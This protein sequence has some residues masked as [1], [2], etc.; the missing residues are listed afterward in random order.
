MS[1]NVKLKQLN[2]PTI[3]Q[4]V[5]NYPDYSL[6]KTIL[7]LSSTCNSKIEKKFHFQNAKI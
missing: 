1:G 2:P 6:Y 4:S 5:L 3:A 7:I